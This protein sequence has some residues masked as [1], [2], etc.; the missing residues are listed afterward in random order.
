M[1][2]W[3]EMKDRW[4]LRE[5]LTGEEV[6]VT[7]GEKFEFQDD[8]G[9]IEVFRDVGVTIE[10]EVSVEIGEEIG[11][12]IGLPGRET[13]RGTNLEIEADVEM[14]FVVMQVFELQT[15]Q[16]VRWS[17]GDV[18]RFTDG[19]M[20]E[21]RA[22]ADVEFSED[23][24]I[25]MRDADGDQAE[26]IDLDH[27]ELFQTVEP[28]DLVYFKPDEATIIQSGTVFTIKNLTTIYFTTPTTLHFESTPI[29]TSAQQTMTFPADATLT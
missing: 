24:E 2:I 16:Q 14:R 28:D 7:G 20:F 13:R 6:S 8:D 1:K 11:E 9:R 17:A 29:T 19:V 15:G 5:Y 21:A 26:D 3:D 25:L 10:E 18:V 4:F 27:N 12:S 23:T 22:D